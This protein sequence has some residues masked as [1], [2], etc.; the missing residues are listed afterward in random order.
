MINVQYKGLPLEALA[1]T[2][3][4]GMTMLALYVTRI[5]RVTQRFRAVMMGAMLSILLFY[6]ITM[7]LG[8]F[9]VATPIVGGSSTLSIGIS[10]VICGIASLSFLLDF[11]MIEQAAANGA[12]QYMEWYGAFGVLVTFIWLYLEVLRLLAELQGR[13]R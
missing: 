12:P 1:L 4:A 3:L 11:D 2:V 10:V 8:L 13:R 6:L 9:G 7:V 5:V